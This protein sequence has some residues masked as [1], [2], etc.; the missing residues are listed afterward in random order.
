MNAMYK[1]ALVLLIVLIS[2]KEK[3]TTDKGNDM[4]AQKLIESE[5][6]KIKLSELDNKPIDL[7]QYKGKIVF[8]NF[9]ATWC[10]PCLQEMPS[11]QKARELLKNEN[12]VYFFASDE[13]V[14]Q[15]EE[16]KKNHSYTLHF[17]KANNMESLGLMALPT[18]YI[19]NPDGKLIF[20]E[21][22]YRKW[23]DK[24]NLDLIINAGK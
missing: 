2:C 17:V 5:L 3:R 4:T 18:T 19:F 1:L 8:I 22:G 15:I 11:I 6:G 10:K 14:E 13:D 21:M 16:F 23:D 9:W 24:N 12:I 20:S 7:N